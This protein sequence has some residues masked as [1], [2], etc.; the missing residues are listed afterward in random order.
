MS[1]AS[2]IPEVN[3]F[4]PGEFEFNNIGNVKTYWVQHKKHVSGHVKKMMAK[5]FW[6]AWK[7]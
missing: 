6:L 5:G 2:S 4:N 1:Y 3:N 7:K